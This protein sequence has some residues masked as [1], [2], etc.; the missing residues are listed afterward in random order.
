M[1]V[2]TIRFVA[3]V[4]ALCTC[5][6]ETDLAELQVDNA[7]SVEGRIKLPP[8][9]PMKPSSCRVSLTTALGHQF[10]GIPSADGS[11][12]IRD[13]PKGTHFLEVFSTELQFPQ[14]RIHVSAKHNGRVQARENEIGDSGGSLKPPGPLLAHLHIAY[15]EYSEHLPTPLSTRAEIALHPRFKPS[16][17]RRRIT[18]RTRGFPQGA[19][20]RGFAGLGFTR[21]PLSLFLRTS[22]PSLWGIPSAFPPS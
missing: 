2:A 21:T 14:L 19:R 16:S 22:V 12:T 4:A 5:V 15:M 3:A 6:A 1:A 18:A 9:E 20:D 8:R 17:W 7:Y 10:V 11:F 13:V